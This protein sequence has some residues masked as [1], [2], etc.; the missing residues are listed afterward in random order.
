F[1]DIAF[2]FG[3]LSATGFDGTIGYNLANPAAAVVIT[4]VDTPGTFLVI[5]GTNLLGIGSDRQILTY[6]VAQ[7]GTGSIFVLTPLTLHTI[8]P[9]D[10]ERANRLVYH[11]QATID[12]QSLRL[13]TMIDELDVQT[14]KPARTIAFDVFDY[15]VFMYEGSLPRVYEQISYLPT[16]DEVKYNPLSVGPLVYVVGEVSGLQTYGACGQMT[17]R[18]EFPGINSLACA[19]AEL[20]GWVT[21]A[22]KITNV[23]VFLDGGSL[24]SASLTGPPRIDVPS[25][26]PVTPWKIAVNLD[27]TSKGEHLIRAVGT[28]AS[29]NR[30]QFASVRVLFPGPGLNCVV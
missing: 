10:F 18:I 12:D 19:G 17:G 25:T 14:L 13:I 1:N 30:R 9:I 4:T 21:G 2:N 11:P 5:N 22:L 7:P 24:G 16:N 27:Q 26:T 29:G 6:T 8:A 20:H 15:G 3:M 28:D 23:E